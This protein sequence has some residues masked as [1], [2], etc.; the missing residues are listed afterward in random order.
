MPERDWILLTS[1]PKIWYASS[2]LRLSYFGQFITS[3]AI[4]E[5]THYHVSFQNHS[6]SIVV[7]LNSL[8]FN[9]SFSCWLV[10]FNFYFFLSSYWRWGSLSFDNH[11]IPDQ[12]ARREIK[13]TKKM[14]LP[15]ELILFPLTEEE[16]KNYK[17]VPSWMPTKK[18]L[19]LFFWQAL[20]MVDLVFIFAILVADYLYTIFIHSS[21][22]SVIKF[23]ENYN[24]WCC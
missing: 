16:R 10:F 7:Y 4:G 8:H 17:V 3:S 18:D 11:F 5:A 12:D 9:C 24:V 14:D 23:F 6:F 20:F 19:G 2:D 1:G 21:Y 15:T 22:V 13:I